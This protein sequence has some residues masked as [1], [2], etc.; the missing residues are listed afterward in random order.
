MA[1][2]FETLFN[3][4][5][6]QPGVSPAQDTF[7][8]RIFGPPIPEQA[9]MG[10]EAT[11]FRQNSAFVEAQK[12]VAALAAEGMPPSQIA[13]NLLMDPNSGFLKNLSADQMKQVFSDVI[14]AMKPKPTIRPAGNSLF[15]EDGDTGQLSLGAEG[16][17]TETGRNPATGDTINTYRPG[18]TFGPDGKPN[19]SYV[20]PS[21]SGQDAKDPN[22]AWWIANTSAP[23]ELQQLYAGFGAKYNVP[24]DMLASQGYQ[25]S[26]WNPNARSPKGAAGISQFMPDTAAERGVDVNNVVSS[27]D[28]QAKYMAEL[29]DRY[30]GNYRHALMAYNWGMGNVDKWLAKGADPAEVPDETVNYVRNITGDTSALPQIT[31]RPGMS[32]QKAL[33]AYLPEKTQATMADVDKVAM[34]NPALI[35]LGAG[36]VPLMAEI[37]IEIGRQISP[38]VESEWATANNYSRV[39]LR[40]LTAD[41]AALGVQ[42]GGQRYKG[43]FEKV[44]ALDPSA[45]GAITDPK[46]ALAAGVELHDIMAARV[47]ELSTYNIDNTPKTLLDDYIKERRLTE[48]VLQDLP[49]R[50]QMTDMQEYV[51]KYPEVLPAAGNFVTQAVDWLNKASGSVKKQAGQAERAVTGGQAVSAPAGRGPAAPPVDID[52]ERNPK[53]WEALPE[54]T[55]YRLPSGRTGTKGQGRR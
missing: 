9:R 11:D 5:E 53:A 39:K 24:P 47:E 30:N 45:G 22:N 51:K 12:Q 23:P 43:P 19:A 31:Y 8:N 25:E 46:D 34:A 35:F 32:F 21:A 18:M 49:T 55:R 17:H 4:P 33:Q 52:P 28:G 40:R 7:I 50:D 38:E 42:S 48:R 3:G 54:G 36:A 15:L 13:Q 14:P 29:R 10:A 41:L 16:G 26:R 27:I 44:M 37:G 20:Y 2:P 1:G 6:A